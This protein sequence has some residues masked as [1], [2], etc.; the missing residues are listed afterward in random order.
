MIGVRL[1][2]MIGPLPK[3][4]PAFVSS[5][6]TALVS[7]GGVTDGPSSRKLT[8][9]PT[10]ALPEAVSPSLSV[11]VTVAVIS[12]ARPSGSL[13]SVG[14]GPSTRCSRAT[15]WVTVSVPSALITSVKAARPPL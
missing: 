5:S 14:V 10:W 11:T 4:S 1:L 2:T 9:P 8:A 12:P 3:F 13:W 7:V 6:T 15:F